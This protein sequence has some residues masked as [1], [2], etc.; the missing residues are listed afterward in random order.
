MQHQ[1][2][3]AQPAAP[4]AR[5]GRNTHRCL[6]A[7]CHT[8]AVAGGFLLVAMALMSV[9]SIVGRWLFAAPIIG[10]YELIEIMG[11]MAVS[12][13]LPYAHWIGA[14][15]IVDFFSSRFSASVSRCLDGVASA[16]LA[17]VSALVAWQM[18]QGLHELRL[19]HDA[20]LMLN[21][22]TWIGYLPMVLSFAL[23]ALV[24]AYRVVVPTPALAP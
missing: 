17:A 3:T 8:L 1:T 13:A 21:L 18:A 4:L 23:L 24:A 12:M 15:V 19:S 2:V 14:H 6:A 5:V 11:A 10:D 20:S 7:L 16:L 9:G 22:P